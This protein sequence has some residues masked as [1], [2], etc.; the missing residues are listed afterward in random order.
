MYQECFRLHGKKARALDGKWTK[1]LH[2]HISKQGEWMGNE[3]MKL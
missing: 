1:D 2:G 3:Y